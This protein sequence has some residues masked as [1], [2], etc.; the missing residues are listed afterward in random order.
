L[1]GQQVHRPHARMARV[2]SEET[3]LSRSRKQVAR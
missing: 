3:G 2:A 1:C